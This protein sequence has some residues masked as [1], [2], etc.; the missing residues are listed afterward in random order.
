MGR[1]N[2]QQDAVEN[3]IQCIERYRQ[4]LPM[5]DGSAMGLPLPTL[6][7]NCFFAPGMTSKNSVMKREA[8]EHGSTALMRTSRPAYSAHLL[9][10]R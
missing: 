6:A 3:L 7:S 9:A 4:A 2:Y 5:T 1:P 10:T 8:V